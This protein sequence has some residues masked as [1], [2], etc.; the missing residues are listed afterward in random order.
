M[1]LKVSFGLDCC[2]FLWWMSFSG[3][4]SRKRVDGVQRVNLLCAYDT[5]VG[6]TSAARSANQNSRPLIRIDSPIVISI[7]MCAATQSVYYLNSDFGKSLPTEF[8]SVILVMRPVLFSLF[9]ILVLLLIPVLDFSCDFF[10]LYL[11][12]LN[13]LR[14]VLLLS[15]VLSLAIVL[16]RPVP[17]ALLLLRSNKVEPCVTSYRNYKTWMLQCANC[18]SV[19]LLFINWQWTNKLITCHSIK[20]LLA[21]ASIHVVLTGAIHW[22]TLRPLSFRAQ[23]SLR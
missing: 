6:C 21:A 16:L 3:L 22:P 2:E 4:E 15:Q 20:N 7:W 10:N 13:A 14:L 18:K 17:L 19:I 5:F 12:L 8:E 1:Q 9:R 23:Y 11:W